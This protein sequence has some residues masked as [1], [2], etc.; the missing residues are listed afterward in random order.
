MEDVRQLEVETQRYLNMKMKGEIGDDDFVQMKKNDSSAVLNLSLNA[1]KQSVSG[2]PQ[3][4][5]HVTDELNS[6]LVKQR[7]DL[8]FNLN[9]LDDNDDDELFVEADEASNVDEFYDA[10]CKYSLLI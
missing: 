4:D 9:L 1:E 8:E 7:N 10:I 5:T 3:L 2:E 6:K